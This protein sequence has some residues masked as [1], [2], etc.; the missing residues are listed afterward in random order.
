MAFGPEFGTVWE[1]YARAALAGG[2]WLQEGYATEPL[3]TGD[4]IVSVASS[5]SILYYSD[6][7]TYEDNTS[8][9]VEIISLPCPVFEQGE[10]LVMQRGA[11]ICTVKS[12]PEKEQACMVFLK[13][14]TDARQNVD[15][16]TRL[17]YLPVKKE[18]FEVYLPEAVE[19]LE[20]PVYRS[21]YQTFLETWK[22]YQFY[23]APKLDTYLE[24]ETRFETLIRQVLAVRRNAW[25]EQSK[26]G[27]VPEWL[28]QETRKDFEAAYRK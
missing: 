19:K 8:E 20:D 1:P 5:A 15:F 7:V 21:L 24:L 3:R 6:E 14:L 13:W 11:G 10:T 12:T 17:G 26:Q 16:V 4:A 25:V 27:E 23:T 18:A 9:Q 2:V 28:I 22:T